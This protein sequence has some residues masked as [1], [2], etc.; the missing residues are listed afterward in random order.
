M[1]NSKIKNKTKYFL[2]VSFVVIA[3]LCVGIFTYLISYMNN[4]TTLT[5]NEVG[6]IYMSGMNDQI[7]KHFETSMDLYWNQINGIIQKVPPQDYE[8]GQKMLDKLRS[9]GELSEFEYLA[10]YTRDGEIESIYGEELKPI[11]SQHFLETLNADERKITLAETVSGKKIALMG[12]S[13]V[14][15][16]KDHQ[17]CT[18]LVAGVS[19]EFFAEQLA[20]EY[21]SSFVYSSIIR[22]T[23]TFVVQN[24]G[25]T[26]YANYF[27]RLRDIASDANKEK[28]E[29][30][31]QTLKEA[32]ENNR[33][34]TLSLSIGE[35]RRQLYCT[36]LP[37]CEWFLITVMPY[38]QMDEA[39]SRLD[40]GRINFVLSCCG[41]I[42]LLFL[43]VFVIY[44][45]LNH[46]Q[47]IQLETARGEAVKANQ[48][49]SEF[50]SNMSHDI[51]TPM[52]AIVGMTSI[53]MSNIDNQSQVQNCLKKIVS[54]SKH[55][56][57]LINNILDMSKI[58]SG[59]LTLNM[60]AVSLREMVEGIVNTIQPQVKVKRQKF[61][62][63]IRNIKTE[64]I[65][66]DEVRLNQVLLNLISNAIKFTPE[67]GAVYLDMS[68]EPS[69]KGERFAR[70]QLKVKDTGIGMTKEFQKKVFES[71]V[72]EDNSRVHKT[73]GAGLGMAI[74]KYIIDAMHGEI[75][76]KS[77]P[78]KGT[79][80]LVVI[81]VEKVVERE[82]NMILPNW[83]MLVV[84]DDQDLC[85]SAVESLKEIGLQAEW[86]LDG[87]AAVKKVVERHSKKDDYQMVLID[88]QMPGMDGI[89]TVRQ[90]RKEV[91][92]N[93]P[94]L[95]ISAY[96]WSDI[97]EE[98]REA[99]VNGFISKPLF[100][101]TLFMGLKPFMD[102][103]N[104]EIIKTEVEE[105]HFE[106]IRILVAE[107]N[108][109]NWE[110]VDTLLQEVGL[111][112]ERA[113]DGQVCVDKFR[114]SKVGYYDMILM[115]IRMPLMSGYEASEI[116]RGMNRADANIP[117]VAMTA[118]AFAEDI[119]KSQECGMNGHVAK[120][121]DMNKMIE[122]IDRHVKEKV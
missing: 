109:I 65:Y 62:V 63:Y 55:L 9:E 3:A 44:Y 75:L 66:C 82:E 91:G 51:R 36:D 117:I 25:N 56:L 17:T 86:T 43:I 23:G 68:E 38:G 34:C 121:L 27:E 49:K 95:I 72:R 47:L 94:I 15:P 114:E 60:D 32:M 10:L 13:T 45:W 93:I 115:D 119:K 50:L 120:P 108:D 113:E 54:S 89:E 4:I 20:F 40:Q 46:K 35:E 77:K 98:A 111:E 122:L 67:E 106:G 102:P 103:D 48:A 80:F 78:G 14:Y 74:T 84:D 28:A 18:A 31:V 83:N 92:K 12:I 59:K 30:D 19:V 58:E 7:S 112:L 24:E 73:E 110:I 105:T 87:E 101:S 41:V 71:F 33:N 11:E 81:D 96:D 6:S 64:N 90:I 2:V 107:D 29:K 53:A 97:E 1:K 22:P 85:E 52:N 116:I 100:K 21:D 69:P 76:V 39:V 26:E 57:G 16:M 118:D 5:I 88:W 8:Y 61:D 37:D 42:I 79:E 104:D 70:F 99:G